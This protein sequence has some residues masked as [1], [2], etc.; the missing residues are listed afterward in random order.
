MR[1]VFCD[2]SFRQFKRGL[3]LGPATSLRE[4][5]LLTTLAPSGLGE[6]TRHT[7]FV[8]PARDPLWLG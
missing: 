1:I 2:R 3:E 5:L 6:S 8:S 7:S 4:Q